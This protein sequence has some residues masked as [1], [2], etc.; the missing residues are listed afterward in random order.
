M[1]CACFFVH[2]DCSEEP[3]F[4]D[5]CVATLAA[6]VKS[7]GD[8]TRVEMRF[9]GAS[10]GKWAEGINSARWECELPDLQSKFCKNKGISSVI[11]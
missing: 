2:A 3:A 10:A 11:L 4:R 5:N 1:L 7:C 9:S 6:D 8:R